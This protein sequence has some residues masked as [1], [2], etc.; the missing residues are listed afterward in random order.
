MGFLRAFAAMLRVNI[1]NMF[2]YRAEILLWSVWG[3]VNPTVL[4]VMWSAAA[5][6]AEGGTIAGLDRNGFAIYYFNLMVIGHMTAAWDVYEM[7]FLVKQGLLS[8]QLL[9]PVLPIWNSITNNLAYKITTL[10]FVLPMWAIFLAVIRPDFSAEPWQLAAGLLAGVFGAVLNYMMCYTVSLVAFWT[11]RL[12]AIG[13]IYFGLCMI[14]GGRVAPIDALPGPV[15]A[16]ARALPF[17]WMFAFPIELLSGMVV[18][19]QEAAT[20]G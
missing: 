19:A 3:I 9:R 1:S 6:G 20:G 15:R 16:I 12:D 5:G 13:E 4:Y 14:F 7:A 11:T 18:S 10:M 8:P 2:Q 17:E